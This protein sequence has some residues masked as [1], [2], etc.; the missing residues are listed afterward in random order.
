[1]NISFEEKI[2]IA[3]FLCSDKSNEILGALKPDWNAKCELPLNEKLL[4]INY[5][6]LITEI[7]PWK[8][9]LSEGIDHEEFCRSF[10]SYSYDTC[11]NKNGYTLYKS[12]DELIFFLDVNNGLHRFNFSI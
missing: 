12:F 5:P 1:M 11:T 2:L 4:I 3:L 9:E 6:L 7:F 10:N 8:D